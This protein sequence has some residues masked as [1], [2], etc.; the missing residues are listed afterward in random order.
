MTKII[1]SHNKNKNI[2]N[3]IMKL[4]AKLNCPA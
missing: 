2:D 4:I 3:E 1:N